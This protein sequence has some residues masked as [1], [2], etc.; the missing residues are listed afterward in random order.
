M[1]FSL[2]RYFF[3]VFGNSC[4]VV[5][6]FEKLLVISLYMFCINMIQSRVFVIFLCFPEL[7]LHLLLS[8]LQKTFK[9]QQ[10]FIHQS[11]SLQKKRM[12]EFKD[13]CEQYL[14]VWCTF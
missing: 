4:E 8:L 3:L 2:L 6:V 12:E 9:E 5:I 11:L 1:R 10:K 13:L 7:F 14:E